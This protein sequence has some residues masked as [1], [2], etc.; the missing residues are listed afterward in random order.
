MLEWK[1]S[2]WSKESVAGAEK[3]MLG[4][5]ISYGAEKQMLKRRISYWSGES[6]VGAEKKMLERRI[7]YWS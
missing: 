3:Q 5:I 4:Q 1:I 2:C 7:S 6:A